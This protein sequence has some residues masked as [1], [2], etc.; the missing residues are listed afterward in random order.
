MA[1]P[2]RH[3]LASRLLVTY[4]VAVVLVLGVLGFFVERAAREVLLSEVEDALREQGRLLAE[5]LPSDPAGIDEVISSLA[6]TI[7]ARVTVVDVDGTVLADSHAAVAEMENH[8]DR[9]EIRAALDGRTGA[10]RSV[11]ESTGF[12]QTYVAAPD[13]EG[14]VVR[15]QLPEN[16]AHRQAT[17]FRQE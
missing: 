14:R 2:R 6:E 5:T 3:P 9:P 12:P 11:S 17:A 1:P 16:I 13:T 8:A 10:D 7:D 4:A 15:L